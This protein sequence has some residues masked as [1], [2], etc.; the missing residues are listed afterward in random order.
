MSYLSM[1]LIQLNTNNEILSVT[2]DNNSFYTLK[3]TSS[4]EVV[5]TMIK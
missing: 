1:S 3:L 4:T 5:F 2:L